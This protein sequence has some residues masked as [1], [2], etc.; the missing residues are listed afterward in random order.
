MG[1]IGDVLKE[2]AQEKQYNIQKSTYEQMCDVSNIKTTDEKFDAELQTYGEM[3]GVSIGSDV[4]SYYGQANNIIS[5]ADRCVSP[6]PLNTSKIADSS[7]K[8]FYEESKV[9]RQ[10]PF[11]F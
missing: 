11:H 2:N 6:V 5:Q 8:G 3:D 9:R 7:N 1:I 4:K 10:I